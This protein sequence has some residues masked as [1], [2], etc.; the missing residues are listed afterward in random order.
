MSALTERGAQRQA[1]ELQA[2][3]SHLQSI[4][5]DEPEL[6]AD[7]VERGIVGSASLS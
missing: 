5:G 2:G 6:L 4:C 1:F 7:M 3:L